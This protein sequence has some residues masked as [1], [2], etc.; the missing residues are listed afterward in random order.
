MSER[1]CIRCSKPL[2]GRQKKFCSHLCANRVSGG[3]RS[4]RSQAGGWKTCDIADCEKPARSRTAALCKMH[5]HRLYRYGTLE[6][7]T[8]LV[9]RGEREP[10]IKPANQPGDRFG[11]LVL[12][13]W[14]GKMWLCQCDCGNTRTAR[15]G[16]LNRAGDRN[17]CGTKANHRS[18]RMVGYRLH[19]VQHRSTDALTVMVQRDSGPTTTKTQTNGTAKQ[20]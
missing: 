17:T 16:D 19:V 11:T 1:T 5:Y 18:M 15:T 12:V 13:E 14:T 9:E 10:S 4:A 6:R 8:T 20:R 3:A 2:V 7:T